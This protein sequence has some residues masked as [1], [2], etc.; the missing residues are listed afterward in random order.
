MSNKRRV[1]P[2]NAKLRP[3]KVVVAA[4]AHRIKEEYDVPHKLALDHVAQRMGYRGYDDY[5][6][7]LENQDGSARED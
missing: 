7:E 2:V 6:K 3:T 5:L 1:L 4:L